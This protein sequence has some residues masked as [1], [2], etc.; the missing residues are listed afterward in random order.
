MKRIR[1]SLILTGI[2][3]IGGRLAANEVTSDSPLAAAEREMLRADT[4]Y[5]LARSTG[6]DTRVHIAA[7][8]ALRKARQLALEASGAG[9]NILL[10]TAAGIHEADERIEAAEE[11]YRNNFPL[12]WALRGGH[13][14]FERFDDTD[15][16]A[17]INAWSPIEKWVMRSNPGFEVLP[18]IVRAE[19]LVP[20]VEIEG[21]V[22][23]TVMAAGDATSRLITVPPAVLASL[24]GPLEQLGA[25]GERPNPEVLAAVGP[26]LLV[27]DAVITDTMAEP[28][29]I[30]R[31]TMSA[32]MVDT[33]SKHV[34]PSAITDGI[35]VDVRPRY[36]FPYL[37]GIL[38]LFISGGLGFVFRSVPSRWASSAIGLALGG[39]G[40]W[41]G[42]IALPLLDPLLPDFNSMALNPFDGIHP[43]M[44]F[45]S[46]AVGGS[47]AF[48]AGPGP[49]ILGLFIRRRLPALLDK[50]DLSRIGPVLAL[51]LAVGCTFPALVFEDE[52]L[53]YSFASGFVALGMGLAMVPAFS[54]IL[55]LR[56]RESFLQW[57]CLGLTVTGL[58]FAFVLIS[59]GDTILP[60]ALTAMSAPILAR[61]SY[62]PVT[63]TQ[64]EQIVE[65]ESDSASA[66][67]LSHPAYVAIAEPAPC[68]LANDFTQ[69]P[70]HAETWV[71]HGPKG[72]GK[73][74]YAQEVYRH[75]LA[76]RKSTGN[77]RP[78]FFGR[79]EP[80]ASGGHDDIQSAYAGLRSLL[81]G[82]LS[83]ENLLMNRDRYSRLSGNI[84]SAGKAILEQVPGV[85]LL[86]G[87]CGDDENENMTTDRLHR[88]IAHLI[89]CLL[90]QHDILLLVDDWQDLD[91]ETAAFLCDLPNRLKP[92]SRGLTLL[93]TRNDD[94]SSPPPP[95]MGQPD[96]WPCHRINIHPL[97]IK[98]APDFIRAAGLAPPDP[99]QSAWVLSLGKHPGDLLPVLAALQDQGEFVKTADGFELPKA[100]LLQKIGGRIPEDILLRH[101]QR[102]HVL[103]P[104]DLLLLELAAQCGRQFTGTQLAAGYGNS[105]KR[106]QLLSRLRDIEDKYGFVE[107]MEEEDLFR[108]ESETL[109]QALLQL[110]DRR[111]G[112]ATVKG[113]RMRE[114][115]REFHHQAAEWLAAHPECG[116]PPE[117]LS[118]HCRKAGV[119]L[120]ALA[121][122]SDYAAALRAADLGLW[123]KVEE[124]L[125]QLDQSSYPPD[126]TEQNQV[127]LLRAETCRA[128]GG[129]ENREKAKTLFLE[130]AREQT[131]DTAEMLMHAYEVWFEKG[132]PVEISAM[133][134]FIHRRTG[135]AEDSRTTQVNRFYTIIGHQRLAGYHNVEARQAAIDQL[136]A[137]ATDLD[138][139]STD[140]TMGKLHCRILQEMASNLS[141][142]AV[143]KQDVSLYPEVI[144]AFENM[145]AQ[146][147]K[148]KDEYGLAIAWGTYASFMESIGEVD[149]AR[150]SLEK[151]LVQVERL[152]IRADAARLKNRMAGVLWALASKRPDEKS[153]LQEQA[154][155]LAWSSFV[156][157]RRMSRE[158]DMA[159]AAVNCIQFGSSLDKKKE[160]NEISVL[161]GQPDW[162]ID[163][164]TLSPIL[165][166]DHFSGILQG[167]SLTE[168]NAF[169]NDVKNQLI[170]TLYEAKKR[171]S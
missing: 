118:N 89:E 74:R 146:K 7:Q 41:V 106:L 141:Q 113:H 104:D 108:F 130:L 26:R 72:S 134:D 150:E 2:F 164:N 119:K 155:D 103:C 83:V 57:L 95:P 90:E 32:W 148:W 67:S 121:W 142:V 138:L 1:I 19:S 84:D 114:F 45:W 110:S 35:G 168:E 16:R 13:V 100:D 8:E 96:H 82:V 29:P 48:F 86:M 34:F 60:V 64:A 51:G 140:E 78:L 88:D 115:M 128:L 135:G 129:Q 85:S 158:A 109:R 17:A 133:L 59:T 11:L 77:A 132:D 170:E 81:K 43:P 120:H 4:L 166:L 9:E 171:T 15:E 112:D 65:G 30:S 12:A 93:V 122:K 28:W 149:K 137:L 20:G 117:V 71:I 160:A 144:A 18:L 156:E 50:V 75:C 145:I 79:C 38:V 66:G 47:L 27:V 55:D 131:L 153:A 44:Y 58:V 37:I 136:K 68:Q 40:L 159:Y 147:Q 143:K 62:I 49:V 102:L 101:Q 73:T 61:L 56:R 23:E 139:A 36:L 24:V 154:W 116:L 33:E 169:W 105:M 76:L 161:I 54:A 123:L 163:S 162:W 97:T 80:N 111:Q 52:G 31:I 126:Q 6:N 39:L 165:D 87:L 70:F 157:S 98:T 25:V 167:V 5:W 107:D 124:W 151:D 99:Q 92:D 21:E 127:K 22:I 42:Q 63:M 10:A 94:P 91:R 53:Q 125:E 69:R 14:V 152:G 3:L 46:I